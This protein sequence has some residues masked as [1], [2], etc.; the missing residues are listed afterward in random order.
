MALPKIQHPISE[1]TQ[2]STG[3]KVK[4]RPFLVKEEKILTAAK[5]GMNQ[6]DGLKNM[7]TAMEQILTNCCLDKKVKI[8]EIPIFDFEI[9]FLRLRAISINNKENVVITDSEDGK[10]YKSE[11]DFNAINVTFPE[12]PV[13]KNIKLPGDIILT[14]KYPSAKIY[15]DKDL[16]KKIRTDDL[17]DFVYECIDKVYKKDTIIPFE[18]SEMI[19]F[20]DNLDHKSYQMIKE[21]IYKLPRIDYAITYKNSLDHDRKEEFKSVADFFFCL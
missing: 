15:Q 13:D 4:F 5:Q 20:L 21:W 16:V 8:D 14:L 10:S 9:F 3:N 6:P 7:F 12:K 2:P 1:F 18:K 19:E 17:F 11:I